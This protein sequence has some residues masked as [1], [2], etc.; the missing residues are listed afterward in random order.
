M[1][2]LTLG[3]HQEELPEEAQSVNLEKLFLISYNKDIR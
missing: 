1:L 2:N 3:L